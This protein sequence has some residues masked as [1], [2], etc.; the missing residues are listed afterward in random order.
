MHEFRGIPVSS[1]IAIGRAVLLDD[2]RPRVVERAI[3]ASA[4]DEELARLDRAIG[5]SIEDL[6]TLRADAERALGKE[7]AAIFAFHQGM[8][9]DASLVEP[10][11]ERVRRRHV[12]AEW[13]AQEQFQDV[14][15]MFS[16][17]GNTAFSTKVDD[18]WDLFYRVLRH[19]MGRVSVVEH[20][21]DEPAVVVAADLTPSQAAAFSDSQVLGF[22]TG[23]GGPTS[24]TAI[25]ARALGIPA[26]VGARGV[27]TEVET[28][29]HVIVDGDTGLIVVDPDED[30]LDHFAKIRESRNELSARLAS[31]ALLEAKTSDGEAVSLLGNI[32]FGHEAAD[33]VIKGGA[34]VG[35]FRTEFLWLTTD[36]EPSEDEQYEQY[37][38]AVE[39]SGGLPVTIRTCDLGADKFTQAAAAIP[40]RNPFLGLRSI[41]YSL[42]NIPG[43]KVQLRAILRASALGPVKVMFPLITQMPEL[44]HAKLVLRDVM[45]DLDDEGVAY[46]REVEIGMMVE[47]PSAAVMASSFARECDFFS[48]GTN[49]L[50]QYTLAVD[51]T[52]ER[53][54]ELYSPVHP[55]V[56]RLMKDVVRAAR[57]HRTAVSICGEMAGDPTYTMLLIGIGL[58][59]LSATPA[60]IPYLKRVIRSVSTAECERLARTVGSFDSEGQV[61]TYLLDQARK[62]FPELVGGRSADPARR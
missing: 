50:V 22:V 35:L 60:R 40:E 23:L 32:E 29:E 58:R 17:M 56:I 45:E 20:D 24:H 18:V 42:K 52:N 6:D 33:V 15:R 41:R 28:G 38:A 36:H 43:L 46:D 31:D 14:A 49:D 54:A 34:G 26:C 39:G 3:K 11:R 21:F 1:G 57:R 30:T 10:I 48:I 13:A 19:L 62:R 53:V 37:R 4:V 8:L 12:A 44:R 16:S 61:A 55:A 47:A 7:A 2:A 5:K 51:R 9:Q 25:F 59:S 27:T